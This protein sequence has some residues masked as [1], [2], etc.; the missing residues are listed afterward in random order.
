MVLI[1]HGTLCINQSKII[2]LEDIH[3][4]GNAEKIKMVKES[5]VEES[6]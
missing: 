3:S 1:L 5:V 2:E 4:Q 6:G